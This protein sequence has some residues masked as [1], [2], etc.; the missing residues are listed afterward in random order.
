MFIDTLLLFYY[1]S[2]VLLRK[3]ESDLKLKSLGVLYHDVQTGRS[4]HGIMECSTYI[5]KNLKC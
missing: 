2:L 4:E 1:F 3:P 5:T